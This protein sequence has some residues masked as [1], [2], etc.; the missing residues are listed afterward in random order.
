MTQKNEIA[1]SRSQKFNR[2]LGFE[3]GNGLDDNNYYMTGSSSI[4]RKKESIAFAETKYESASKKKPMGQSKYTTREHFE[5]NMN[6][7]E[8][9]KTPLV[10]TSDIDMSMSQA[11]NS[12]NGN[13]NSYNV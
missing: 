1:T 11:G 12:N 9:S 3:D 7:N 6:M 8:E 2:K 4:F 13:G 5:L 10:M